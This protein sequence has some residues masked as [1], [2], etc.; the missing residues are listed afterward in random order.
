MLMKRQ[1]LLGLVLLLA[2]TAAPA[3]A[4]TLDDVTLPDTVTVDGTP[5]VLNGI[6]I[7]KYSIFRFH[8]YVAGLYVAQKSA[9]A[10]A[11]IAS[12]TPKQVILQFV[13]D[14]D[15]SDVQDAWNEGFKQNNPD[16]SSMASE[17]DLVTGV[18]QGDV[19]EGQKLTVT[20]TD[21]GASLETKGVT[22]SVQN[23]KFAEA[24]LR[25]WIGP[26]PPDSNLKKDLLGNESSSW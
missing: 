1:L 8:V 3:Y 2:S 14:V 26:N 18:L 12:K 19:D 21:K 10:D 13:R 16:A 11:I 22:K 23:P 17:L 20:V 6:G 7:R 9:D 24:L 15:G 5:L 4:A 25:I